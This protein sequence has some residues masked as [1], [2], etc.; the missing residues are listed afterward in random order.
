MPVSNILY[1]LTADEKVALNAFRKLTKGMTD[2][3]KAT[4]GL[5]VETVRLDKAH[6]KLER[7]AKKTFEASKSGARKYRDQIRMLNQAKQKGILTEKQ[8][9]QAV[10]HTKRRFLEAGMAGRAAFGPK[11]LSQVK[12]MAAAL[13]L[14]V[15]V[16]GA[17]AKITQGYQTWLDIAREI[18]SETKKAADEIVAFAAL[19]AGGTRAARVQQA[20]ALAVRFGVTDRG[21][22]FDVVQA[23]QSAAGGADEPARFRQ[24]LAAAETVFAAT[25]LGVSVETGKEA[26]IFGAGVGLPPGAAIRKAFVAGEQSARTPEALAKVGQALPFFDDKDLAFAAAAVLSKTVGEQRLEVFTRRAGLGLSSTSG[27]QPLFEQAGLGKASRLEKL[28]FLKQQG[29]ETPEQLELAG[30][31]DPDDAAKLGRLRELKALKGKKKTPELAAEQKSLEAG[32]S[33]I[34]ESIAVSG[35]VRNFAE[36]ERIRTVIQREAVPGLLVK[37]RAAVEEELPTFKTTRMIKQAT[38]LFE[39]ERAFNQ[40]AAQ[41]E[42]RQR[43]RGIAAERLGLTQGALGGRLVTEEGR[44]TRGAQLRATLEG[45]VRDALDRSLESKLGI[46]PGVTEAIRERM[47]EAGIP[48]ARLGDLQQLERLTEEVIIELKE[49][50]GRNNGPTDITL[51]KAG[52]LETNTTDTTDK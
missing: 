22:A 9:A 52:V 48:G 14:G 35:L 23:L 28:R 36:L 1:K 32:L 37:K 8:H 40:E 29:I 49:M 3:E 18:S 6:K 25:Q 51:G 41:L 5:T 24:G 43:A 30:L 16:G 44:A 17:I 26:E 50:N 7:Q 33:E 2:A 38:A 15:G 31:V 4:T 11:A 47:T 19:Q 12:S 13:G 45:I 27:L 39:A 21:Q 10:A 20:Q 42:L 34:R 46:V